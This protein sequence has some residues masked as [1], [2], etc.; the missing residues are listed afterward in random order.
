MVIPGKTL[1][2]TLLEKEF[3]FNCIKMFGLFLK[4]FSASHCVTTLKLITFK[5]R[6][7]TEMLLCQQN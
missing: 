4:N 7:N 6:K 5:T 1:L 3:T 2:L